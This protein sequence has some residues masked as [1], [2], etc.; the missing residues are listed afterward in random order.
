MINLE[1]AADLFK[2]HVATF[3]DY[4]D[5]AGEDEVFK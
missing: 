5:I 2:N 3:K 1:T 4:G